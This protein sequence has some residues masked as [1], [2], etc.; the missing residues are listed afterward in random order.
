MGLPQCSYIVN[1]KDSFLVTYK[2][3]C[4]ESIS[5]ESVKFA[6]NV[7]AVFFGS[8]RL[9]WGTWCNH[10][11]VETANYF[12]LENKMIPK[13]DWEYRQTE[14]QP[15]FC[16]YSACGA[17]IYTSQ[18]K[19]LIGSFWPLLVLGD[20]SLGAPEMELIAPRAPGSQ[21]PPVPPQL[22]N[23]ALENPY[24]HPPRDV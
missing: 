17:W 14:R 16:A 23:C 8:Q 2:S 24:L 15:S 20:I 19:E 21:L 6:R 1:N 9:S 18:G 10:P 12:C 11:H 7:A 4:L 5:Y 3:M 22:H 13:C